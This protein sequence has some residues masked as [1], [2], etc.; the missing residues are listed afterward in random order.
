LTNQASQPV[1]KLLLRLVRSLMQFKGL[2]QNDHG[3]RKESLH[4]VQLVRHKFDTRLV[5]FNAQA[6]FKHINIELLLHF[7]NHLALRGANLSNF[8]LNVQ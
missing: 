5:C 8:I 7:I 3:V 6:R 1:V 4:A 2:M